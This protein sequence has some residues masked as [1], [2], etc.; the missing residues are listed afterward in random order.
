MHTISNFI[1]GQS[2][3]C[4]GAGSSPV[5]DPSTGQ[6][7]ARLEHC[8]AAALAEAMVGANFPMPTP[9]GSYSHGRWTESAFGYFNQYGEDSIRFFTRTKVVT[10][11]WPHGEAAVERSFDLPHMS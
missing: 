5:Y 1:N 3:L 8:D 2:I 6:V 11:R 7:Q 9:V 10:Q 4:S